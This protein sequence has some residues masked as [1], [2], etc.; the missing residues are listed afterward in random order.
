VIA[1]DYHL[2]P[3]FPHK[4]AKA[5]A[6]GPGK[7]YDSLYASPFGNELVLEM[8]K[9]ILAGEKLGQ[10]PAADLLFVSFSAN[11]VT[12]HVWGPNSAEVLDAT[13]R[14]DRQ[15]ADLLTAID[16]Q[17]GLDR[18]A[19]ALTGDHGVKELPQVTAAAGLGGERLDVNAVTKDLNQLLHRSVCGRCPKASPTC[20]AILPPWL[21]FGPAARQLEPDKQDDVLAT[22]ARDPPRL[23]GVAELFTAA[24]Q[25]GRRRPPRTSLLARLAQLLRRALRR[26][27]H[28]PRPALVRSGQQQHHGPRHRPLRGP[29]RAHPAVRPG[30]P[31]G[32]LPAAG[33]TRWTSPRR[34]P[35]SWHRTAARLR[36][37]RLDQALGPP[38][39]HERRFDGVF[40]RKLA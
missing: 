8:V 23:D 40:S 25:D 36:R 7:A 19:I 32:S 18:C 3:A 35:P 26:H 9:R 38:P 24:D 15:I 1:Y 34:W 4:H 14:T 6:K 33:G 20:S 29:P 30:R 17:V 31:R 37:Q 2:G 12:G 10:G 22:T 39:A 21:W 13:V 5:D 11:D 27:L 16:K 28:P